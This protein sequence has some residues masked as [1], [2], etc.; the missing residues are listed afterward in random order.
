[1]IQEVMQ[2]YFSKPITRHEILRD[3]DRLVAEVEV[4][5]E[6][7]YLKGEKQPE[8]FVETIIAFTELM[9]NAGLPF[10]MSEQALDGKRYVEH[11][12]LLFILERKGI[13]KEIKALRQEHL[14]ELGKSLGKQHVVSS[15]IDLRFGSGTSWGMFGG[16]K[17]NE[18]G[19]YDENELSYLDLVHCVEEIGRFELELSMVKELY[20]ARR[21]ILQ[22]EWSELPAGPVQGDLLPYNLLFQENKISVIYDYDIAGDEVFVNE[23]VANA[24]YLAWHHD[25]EGNE[26]PEE[27]YNT[28]INAYT[29]E[30]PL[31]NRELEMVPH[32]FAIIRA[33][34]YDRIEEGIEK[35]KQGDGK[36]FLD[37]TIKL[38]T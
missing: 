19:D 9:S 11:E 5:G 12:N 4:D 36:A 1:M 37:E 38:L 13:G 16:N 10:I 3:K 28:Y 27:R 17:T 29:S 6:L 18:L 21:A 22:A 32:L 30:R 8:Q 23:C 26:T 7:F 24:I 15:T 35:I 31:L 20:L 14:Q 2:R 33:F 34:R 25:F